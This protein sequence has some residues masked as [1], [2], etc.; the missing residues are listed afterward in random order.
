MKIEA[1]PLLNA[2][3]ELAD[4]HAKYDNK[5]AEG[6]KETL[7]KTT[8][9]GTK[10]DQ[11]GGMGFFGSVS[12]IINNTCGPAM[13][14]IPHILHTA[15]FVPVISCIVVVWLGSSLTITMLSEAIQEIPG[16]HNFDRPISFS[17]A[18]ELIVGKGWYK[19][20]ETLFLIS[21]MVRRLPHM[22]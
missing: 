14:G 15:G 17:S 20:T 2:I 8:A 21:C 13:M 22:L 4:A 5:S 6:R 11:L 1:I 18:F 10:Q 3:E 16:N 19:L 7:E 9:N 12:L